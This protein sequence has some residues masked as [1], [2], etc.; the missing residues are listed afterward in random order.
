MR[1][2][3]FEHLVECIASQGNSDLLNYL[4]KI[5]DVLLSLNRPSGTYNKYNAKLKS[6]LDLHKDTLLI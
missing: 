2:K 3:S 4:E 6:P 5:F 1:R